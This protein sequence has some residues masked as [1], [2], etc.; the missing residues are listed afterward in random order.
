MLPIPNYEEESRKLKKFVSKPLFDDTILRN[1]PEYPRISIITPS[2]NQAQFLEHTI[3]SVLNQNYPN[4]EYIIMDGGS[5]DDSV[6]IIRKYA[7]HFSYRQSKSDGGQPAAITTGFKRSDGELLTWLNSDDVLLP[8]AIHRWATAYRKNP[9]ADVFYG[10]NTDIDEC[11]YIQEKAKHPPYYSKLA[12]LTAPYIAQPGTA[13]TRRIWDCVGGVD[14]NMHC[15]FDYDLWYRFMLLNARFIHVGGW[16]AGFR[17]HSESKGATW[18]QRY[19]EE[20]ALIRQRYKTQMGSPFARLIGR[21]TL[22]IIQ[23]LSGAYIDKLMFRLFRH[24]R[25]KVYRP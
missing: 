4:L 3:L 24:G 23:S 16:V 2:L 10:N 22:M 18:L 17:R 25:L 7:R 5:T 11:G 1:D 20:H 21:L 13:F 9:S 15:A 6:D 14:I 12:W 19:A 8:N